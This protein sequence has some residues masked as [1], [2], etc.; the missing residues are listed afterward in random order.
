MYITQNFVWNFG[1]KILHFFCV[2]VTHF[3]SCG[4]HLKIFV[5]ST[6][7][8]CFTHAY[9]YVINPQLN[10]FIIITTTYKNIQNTNMH[11]IITLHNPYKFKSNRVSCS[12]LQFHEHALYP[13]IQHHWHAAD[14]SLC[15][16]VLVHVTRSFTITTACL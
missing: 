7:P 12:I 14:K 4:Y 10:L 5:S 3:L 13:W 15:L 6:L 1:Q 2:T 9:F 11:K 8:Y 16:H